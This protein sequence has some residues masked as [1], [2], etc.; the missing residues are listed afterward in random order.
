M[1]GGHY[2]ILLHLDRQNADFVENEVLD[3]VCQMKKAAGKLPGGSKSWHARRHAPSGLVACVDIDVL[4][5]LD[6]QHTEGIGK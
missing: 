5:F 3:P 2:Q 4:G 6:E 1:A